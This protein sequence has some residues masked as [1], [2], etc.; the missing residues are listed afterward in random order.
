MVVNFSQKGD[1]SAAITKTFDGQHLC[2]LCKQIK[3]AKA[4]EKKQ[5]MRVVAEKLN[6]FHQ[7]SIITLARPREFRVQSIGNCLVVKRANEPPTP[8]PRAATV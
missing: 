5:E 8:P 2:P 6:L 7:P 3:A 1:L 4:N